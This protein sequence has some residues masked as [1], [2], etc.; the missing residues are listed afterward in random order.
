MAVEPAPNP[1]AV[2]YGL[3]RCWGYGAVSF[4]LWTFYWFYVNRR[5]IDGE[6]GRG[7]D[8]ALMHSLGLFVPILN[9][10]ILY[11]LWRDI[12]ELRRRFGMPG[13]SVVGYV[14]GAIFLAPVFYSLVLVKLN[15]Y[16]DVRTQGLAVDA[17][18]TS[19][20]KGLLIA[21]GVLFGLW[22]LFVVAV[23]V[24]AIVAGSN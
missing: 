11:W 23:I 17:P 14:I 13:F 18:T 5:L 8:D 20:E 15:E 7:R 9:Y 12:D 19:A 3:G 10:F 4:G 24:V 21:G 1:Y 6:S 2:K 22:A 16:W